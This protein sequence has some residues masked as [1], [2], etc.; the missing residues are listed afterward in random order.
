MRQEGEPESREVNT[1]EENYNGEKKAGRGRKFLGETAKARFSE[2]RKR[3]MAE[4]VGKEEVLPTSRSILEGKSVVAEVNQNAESCPGGD[5]FVEKQD[6][7]NKGSQPR[8]FS[9]ELAKERY[10]ARKIAQ[11]NQGAE[12]CSGGDTFVEKQD[13]DNKGSP[14]KKF[15][16]ELAKERYSARKMRH[17]EQRAVEEEEGKDENLGS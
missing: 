9:G 3:Q 4:N 16:G 17:R 12:S 11:V 10:S 2:R 1:I 15:P 14:Q 7:D 5:T 8:K 13:G 6:G